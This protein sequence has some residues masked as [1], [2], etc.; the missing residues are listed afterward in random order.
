MRAIPAQTFCGVEEWQCRDSYD[1][2]I[3]AIPSSAGSLAP[4]RAA[5]GPHLVRRV[6][7]ALRRPDPTGGWFDLATS[8]EISRGLR[9]ADAGDIVV[10]A[11]GSRPDQSVITELDA[12]R[13]SCQL[14][15]VLVGDDS[16]TYEVVAGQSGSMLHLDAHE[17]RAIRAGLPLNH[18]DFIARILDDQPQL[19]LSQWGRRGLSPRTPPGAA[20]NYE[21]LHDEEAVRAR[22]A[23]E[24]QGRWH[25]ALDIDV[26]NP[27]EMTSVTCPLP[28]GPSLDA[29]QSLCCSVNELATLSVA[30]FAP[31]KGVQSALEAFALSQALLRIIDAT[32][33][34]C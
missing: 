5:D 34:R 6:S 23:L 3:V 31:R 24:G 9:M 20:S 17:D 25:I 28:G 8:E 32:V 15:V 33:A 21:V 14:L 12:I 16:W 22:V 7:A 1:V 18:A 10:M 27:T 30:E 19:R 29:I 26:V 13:R 11:G 2:V 4:S